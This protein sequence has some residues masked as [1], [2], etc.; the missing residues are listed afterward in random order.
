MLLTREASNSTAA[1][2]LLGARSHRR[3]LWG[4][5]G[6]WDGLCRQDERADEYVIKLVTKGSSPKAEIRASLLRNEFEMYQK[7]EAARSAGYLY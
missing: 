1:T 5:S 7:I 6:R 2:P 4:N 3:G